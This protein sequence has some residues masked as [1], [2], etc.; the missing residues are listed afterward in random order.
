MITIAP[1]T[2]IDGY[3]VDHRRQYPDKTQVIA[4]NL[5]ARGTRRTKTDKVIFFGLQYFIK[6]YLID[7]WNENFFSQPLDKVLARFT[8]RINN[9]LGPNQVG[10]SHIAALHQ[11]GYLPISIRALPEGSAYKLRIP[12]LLIYNTQPDFFWLTNYLETILSTTVWGPCTSATTAFEYKKLLTKYALETV[13]DA[14]FV[15]WQGHD[16]SFRG[17]FGMEAA[18]M[19]GGAHLTSFTGTDTIPAIDWL[20]GYYG[21]NSDTELI[22][23]SVAATE[24]SVACS[25]ILNFVEK[26]RGYSNKELTE[27]ELMDLADIE[28]VKHLITEVYPEGIVSIVA[29]S[30]DYWNTITNTARALKDVIMARNGKVVFRPD[31]GNPVR[32]VVGDEIQSLDNEEYVTNLEKAGEWMAD[33]MLDKV[34]EETPHGECGPWNV[35]GHFAYQGKAYQ[36]DVEIEWNRHDKRYYYMDGH[37]V[38]S[39]KEVTLTP[40]QKGSIQCLWDIFGGTTTATGHK[41]LDSHV[42][43]IYGD[44]ITLDRA[45][46]IC[47]G[48]KKKGFASINIVFGVGSFT[49]QYVTRDTDQYAVKATFAVVDGKDINIFKKPKTGDGMKNSATGLVAV[50]KDEAGEYYLKDKATWAEVEN[51]ELKEVFRDGKLLVDHTLAEIRARINSNVA[52]SLAK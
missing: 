41:L 38:K 18:L 9:Y 39:V 27:D 52:Q 35:T 31:T 21:A 22:G 8:R 19:S 32:V 48:L 6:E 49:Y 10:V 2:Q 11:L 51:C 26:V 44:S 13:G 25:T 1:E 46:K 4:S 30:F 12:S 16:F 43:L 5:T 28:Y 7:Q 23:G 40:E 17:M 45:E 20:E 3:K 33:G 42:G 36:V 50:F 37:T 15:Q 47:E 24:H 14:G 29:D 34:G